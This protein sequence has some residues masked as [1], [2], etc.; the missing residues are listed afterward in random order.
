MRYVLPLSER[1][2]GLDPA[3]GNPAT[4]IVL[5]LGADRITLTISPLA[6]AIAGNRLLMEDGSYRLTEDGS[7][8]LLEA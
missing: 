7:K 3:T 1:I 5:G 2:V 4:A 8:R 6:P